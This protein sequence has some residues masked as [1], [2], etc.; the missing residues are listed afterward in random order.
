[1][2]LRKDDQEMEFL[3][4]LNLVLNFVNIKFSDLGWLGDGVLLTSKLLA[5]CKSEKGQSFFLKDA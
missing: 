4:T 3:L 1:M 5:E 2:T